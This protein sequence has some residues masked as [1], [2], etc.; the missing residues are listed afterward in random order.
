MSCGDRGGAGVYGWSVEVTVREPEKGKREPRCRDICCKRAAEYP[1]GT[2]KM[3][4]TAGRPRCWGGGGGMGALVIAW[5]D[6]VR[7]PCFLQI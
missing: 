5:S 7:C 6:S 3:L 2:P 1:G 4:G